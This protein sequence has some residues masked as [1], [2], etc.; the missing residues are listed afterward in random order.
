MKFDKPED[1]INIAKGDIPA[2]GKLFL[3]GVAIFLLLILIF[4][5]FYSIGP[6]EAG[7]LR[8]FGKYVHTTNPGL[9]FKLPFGVDKVTPVKVKHVF[10]QE[11]GFRTIKA[12]VRSQYAKGTGYLDE[13][14]MLT[15]DLNVAVVEW[16][17][18]YTI[19]DAVKYLFK[20]RNPE[21]TLKDIA[22]VT[23]RR[24][25]GDNSI[26]QVLLT[27][28]VEIAN[29]VKDKLQKILDSYG[30]GIH[31]VTVKLQDVNPP[32]RVKPAFNEVNE[33]KQEKERMINDAYAAYNKRIPKARGNA[34]KTIRKAEGYAIDRTNRAEGEAQ[35]FLVM[36][37][38]YNKAK[39]VTRRRLYLETLSE[40]LP[41]AGNKYIVDPS[42]ESLLPIL[43]IKD[44]K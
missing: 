3:P 1:I 26:D 12:G 40:A 21:A 9:H 8:R 14:L 28:R 24:T 13:S 35:R 16:I 42:Q 33:A 36:L 22:E 6:N 4:T 34:E 44:E 11:F 31:I 30:T 23:I 37:E 10:K 39:E 43:K 18:Q 7:V 29:E 41:K 2:F 32:E 5:S 25:V 20:V 17:V 27:R 19:K 38:E 15:G